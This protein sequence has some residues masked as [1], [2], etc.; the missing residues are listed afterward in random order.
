M[1]SPS[2]RGDA[3]AGAG[4]YYENN[5]STSSDHN[6]INTINNTI[7][8]SNLSS[9][10]D[11]DDLDNSADRSGSD[12]AT[13]NFGEDDS[14]GQTSV[15]ANQEDAN[16]DQEETDAF[17]PYFF[18]AGLPAHSTVQVRGKICLPPKTGTNY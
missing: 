2:L 4:R 17:N 8:N 18:I 6:D 10:M 12:I 11:Q 16:E 14:E 3:P 5:M 7:Q 9:S 1:F 13:N 15:E